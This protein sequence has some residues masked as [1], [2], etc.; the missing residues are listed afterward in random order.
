MITQNEIRKLQKLRKQISRLQAE[1]KSLRSK[2]LR[3]HNRF[4]NIEAGI[5]TVEVSS[6]QAEVFSRKAILAS[7]GRAGLRELQANVNLTEYQVVSIV[8]SKFERVRFEP[9]GFDDGFNG[10][11]EVD[12]YADG[13]D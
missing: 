7:L 6:R 5:L 11:G 13:D 9:T 4:D 12:K 1:E 8:K 2:V 3:K 10:H